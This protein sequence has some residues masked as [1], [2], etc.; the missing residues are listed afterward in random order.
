MESSLN[1][2]TLKL[3]ITFLSK[4]PIAIQINNH[5]AYQ[6]I[7]YSVLSNVD[8]KLIQHYHSSSCYPFTYSRFK[9]DQYLLQESLSKFN[10]IIPAESQCQWIIRSCDYT[11]IH[12]IEEG[13][14]LRQIYAFEGNLIQITYVQKEEISLNETYFHPNQQYLIKYHLITPCIFS[15]H[16]HNLMNSF[17]ELQ[18]VII[19]QQFRLYPTE[20]KHIV[21]DQLSFEITNIDLK[22]QSGYLIKKDQI[23][24]ENGL[25]GTIDILIVDNVSANLQFLLLNSYL[26]LGKKT[27]LGF[28]F[29]SIEIFTV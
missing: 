14:N 1:L 15:N 28:G 22:R 23:I 20:L 12:S 7:I 2:I 3:S 18:S 16:H 8:S 27:K 25:V 29:I 17:K 13:I 9:W 21:K 19:N 11:F 6:Q 4:T 10:Y 24:F 26:G 5:K